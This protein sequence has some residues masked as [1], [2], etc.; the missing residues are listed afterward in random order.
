MGL[1]GRLRAVSI[2]LGQLMTTPDLN[3]GVSG[4]STIET[5]VCRA[6]AYAAARDFPFRCSFFVFSPS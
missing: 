2:R 5:Q 6:A 1:V 4:G 3:C